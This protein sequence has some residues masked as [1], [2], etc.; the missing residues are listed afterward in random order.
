MH[1]F[2]IEPS[3]SAARLLKLS[4]RESYHALRVLRVEKGERVVALDGAGAELLCQV[5]EVDRQGVTL[6]VQQRHAIPPLPYQITLV[7]A[8]PKGKNM[9]L[10]VQ[11]AAELGAYRLVP[12]LADRSVP[13]LDEERL[14]TKLEKWNDIAIDSI[15]QC[16]SAWLPK[17]ELPM[18]PASFLASGERPEFQLIATLQPDAK[19]PRLHFQD[20][21]AE[22]KRRPKSI[23]VWV[24]PEGDF[25]P[26][27]I[28]AIRAA[29][30]LPITLGQLILRSETAAFY[31]LSVLNYELQSP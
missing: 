4:A 25:T 18:K 9:D 31:C 2:Y 26:A 11:K 3:Q 1:R 13:Q 28:N 16:G 19:H 23:F 17:I 20:F 8:I 5:E 12:L 21:V 14:E 7:Q 24:G 27:E 29:G 22:K 10:I 6:L 15:K 30:A